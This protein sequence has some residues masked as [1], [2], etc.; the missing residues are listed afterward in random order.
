VPGGS[1][2]F[3]APAVTFRGVLLFVAV[4]CSILPSAAIEAASVPGAPN[5][6]Q[7][8]PHRAASPFGIPYPDSHDPR[9]WQAWRQQMRADHRSASSRPNDASGAAS[10]GIIETI[11]GA[12]PFQKPLNALEAG[13]GQIQGIAED[14]SG[15]LYIASCDLGAVLKID[16][17]SNATVFAGRPLGTGPLATSGDG[18]PAT[19]ARF[20]CPSGIAI[21]SAGSV[22]VS[23]LQEGTVRKI[24]GKTGIIHTIAG[25]AGQRTYTGDGG[26]ATTATLTNP[27][28]LALDGV[29][30][31]FIND[32]PIVRR[33]NLTT[34]IIQTVVGWNGDPASPPCTL[35]ASSTCPARQ[36]EIAAFALV[37]APGRLYL[38]LGSGGL[39]SESIA[40]V[41]LST[42][43]VQM[44]AGGGPAAGSSAMYPAIGAH[45]DPGGLA[46]DSAGNV[47]FTELSGQVAEINATDHVMHTIAGTGTRSDFGDDGPATAAG[48]YL[49]TQICL[50]A[51]RGIDIVDVFRIRSFTVGGNIV[52]TAGNGL[53][54]YFGDNGPASAA[55]LDLPSD[56]VSDS[57]GNIYVA[58]K[59]NGL[60]RRI[61][62]TTGVITT[63]AGGGAF[64][65]DGDGGPATS[66]SLTPFALALDQ[67]NHLYVRSAYGIR[68]VDLST[69]TISTLISSGLPFTGSM[70]FDDDHT[71]YLA[72]APLG[73]DLNSEVVAVDT[74]T[75]AMTTVAGTP[76]NAPGSSTDDGGPATEATLGNPWGLALDGKGTLFISDEYSNNIRSVNLSTG[77]IET[78][79][80]QEE[81]R[82][83][84]GSYGGDGGLAIEAFLA[85]PTG[86]AYDNGGHLVF[87]DSG[88]DVVRQI[89]LSN[90]VI[91]TIAG[92]HVRGFGGDGGPAS[93]AMFYFPTAVTSDPSG[94][95][96]IADTYNS[97]VRRVMLHPTSL[98]ATLAYGG[99]QSPSGDGIT[100]TATYS[101][102]SFG[103]APTGTVTFL[104]GSTVLGAGAIA[105][106]TDGSGNYVAAVTVTSA[107]ANGTNITAQ[108]SGDVN[109]AAVTTIATFQPVTPSYT[110]WAKPASV[111]VKQ[112]SSGNIAFTVT[113]QN[114]FNQ[115]VSFHC[116]SATLPQGVTCSFSP[117]SVTPDG[118]SAVT[119]TL[120]VQTSG[121]GVAALDRRTKPLLGPSSGWLPRSGAVL[122]LVLFGIPRV[123]R[124]T[125]L[126]GTT[127][128]L[129]ALCL[130][131]VLGCGGSSNSGGN[132]QNANATPSG[133]Y[134]IQVTTSVGASNGIPP[135]TVSL[136]VTQ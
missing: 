133:T 7:A 129:F 128:M 70:V 29:G 5:A 107:P 88:N 9:A 121:A 40:T 110:V 73:D 130:T 11:A 67:A 12:V 84:A 47:F 111:T 117:A 33:I 76:R 46:V 31:L 90:N 72:S 45:F 25:I 14:G 21:D 94:N 120:T 3:E 86:M 105:E 19:A 83:T 24:D 13:F 102:L 89:D 52:A 118:S 91:T 39:I 58:D 93:G 23:D 131:G 85:A 59:M 41:D 106:A 75:G 74:G 108:Y 78:A 122:A 60:V 37:A 10:G 126:S 43:T 135:L 81:D 103:F 64:G 114:G 69:G 49:P 66:A 109:Y 119:T 54:N 35:S 101:G 123:R 51:K 116:G 38:A 18:G 68:V 42:G 125:W 2:S 27:E 112:G 17:S 62:A 50:S 63:I 15:N 61:D 44:I 87:L 71:L 30:N 99:G 4:L 26:P 32:V 1:C 57:Q 8:T 136:T 124:R 55:G 95:L 79:A 16:S 127:L 97:R 20:A 65:V 56:V 104:N 100:F 48:I 113:P 53:A 82:Y 134:S 98:K 36:A 22:Y 77:I 132:T 92:N 80:G 6:S 28:G 96:I 115:A 34:G